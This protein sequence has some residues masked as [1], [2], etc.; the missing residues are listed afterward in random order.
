LL[1]AW[2]NKHLQPRCRVRRD[3]A[4]RRR[5]GRH[6]AGEACAHDQ[7]IAAPCFEGTIGIEIKSWERNYRKEKGLRKS[8]MIALFPAGS[9]QTCEHLCERR[10]AQNVKLAHGLTE[11]GGE[12]G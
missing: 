10:P 8:V 9:V 2:Q 11:T 3:A 7:K 5:S 6:Q 1:K 4:H 12:V